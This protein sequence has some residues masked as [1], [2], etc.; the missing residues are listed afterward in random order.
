MIGIIEIKENNR[1][2][3]NET[4]IAKDRI[5]I[6]IKIKMFPVSLE[7]RMKDSSFSSRIELKEKIFNLNK[8]SRTEQF[9]NYKKKGYKAYCLSREQDIY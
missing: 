6:E 1:W 7:I 8:E 5:E 4:L 2:K 9:H 3:A